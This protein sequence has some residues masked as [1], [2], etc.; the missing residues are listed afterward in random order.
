VK[1]RVAPK[2]GR[3]LGSAKE[4][5]NISVGSHP[6]FRYDIK[7]DDLEKAMERVAV[8]V[9]QAKEERREP[10]FSSLEDTIEQAVEKSMDAMQKE[11][12]KLVE[13]SLD[14]EKT[15]QSMTKQ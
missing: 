4:G 6:S 2:G 14:I 7:P 1:L 9:A 12:T 15:A 13:D 10:D 8:L 3:P 5:L 11:V